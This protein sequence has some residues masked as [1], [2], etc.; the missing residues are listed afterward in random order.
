VR[1]HLNKDSFS[2]SAKIEHT[3]LSN[4]KSYGIFGKYNRP[5]TDMRIKEDAK[6]K[7]VMEA[8]LRGKVNYTKLEQSVSRLLNEKV[9]VFSKAE[10]EIF[11]ECLV[12]LGSEERSFYERLILKAEGKH[13]QNDLFNSFQ[14]QPE[15]VQ[16]N[17]FN[18]Y[19]FIDATSNVTSSSPLKEKLA[20]I[21]KAEK[22][23]MPYSSLFR[24][25]QSEPI[26]T[27][28]QIEENGIFSS[29]PPQIDFDF[30]HTTLDNLNTHFSEESYK[31]VEAVIERNR[32]ICEN[33][34][35]AAWIKIEADQIV[36]CYADGGRKI[37]DFDIEKE[38]EN[39]YFLP[40]YISLYN[41]I[42]NSNE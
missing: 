13:V 36:T 8:S 38:F 9:A 14:E 35:N 3:L 28:A 17:V 22:I 37:T 23:L 42:M 33:R 11:S 6:F 26:W 12:S 18:L 31:K 25:L 2:F 30:K 29:F 19:G 1:K 32:L 15:L 7:E 20:I 34:N 24:T 39:N 10:L 5:F 27:R 4:Q 21:K 16:G 41:Q 40:T